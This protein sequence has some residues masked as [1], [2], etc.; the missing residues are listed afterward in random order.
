[1]FFEP[2]AR[3][4]GPHCC[5]RARRNRGRSFGA[6]RGRLPAVL[7]LAAALV[8]AVAPAAAQQLANSFG[9]FAADQNAPIAIEANR[10]DVNDAAKTAV[11]TG[12]VLAKQGEFSIR[13]STLTVYYSD[14]PS[15]GA[16]QVA[17]AGPAAGTNVTR[18]VASGKVLV[19]NGPDNTATGD[20]ADF[21]VAAQ[22]IVISGDVVLSQATNV[23]RGKSLEIDLVSGL[24]QLKG[25]R[26]SGLFTRTSKPAGQ[27]SGATGGQ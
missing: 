20:E 18:I 25:G 15:P 7:A 3:N 19:S 13:S 27:T 5:D 6:E 1:M 12:N 23:L 8:L 26:I 2:S 17:T 10:L 24:S 16:G 14:Q 4:A 21:D 11:F 22:K 9:G